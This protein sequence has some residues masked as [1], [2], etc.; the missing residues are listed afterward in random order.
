MDG[1]DLER[2]LSENE[3]PHLDFKRAQYPFIGATDE[4]KCELLKD[5]LAFAN[6]SRTRD[7][8]I[9]IGVEEVKGGRGIL[10]GVS[11]H[12]DDA[13]L[14]QFVN[15]KTQRAIHFS[16]QTVVADGVS[17]DAI[18]V[19][20]QRRPFFLRKDYGKLRANVVYFRRGTTT[21]EANPDEIAA[22]GEESAKL[23]ALQPELIVQFAHARQ[24]LG[25]GPTT[26]TESGPSIDF[27]SLLPLDPALLETRGQPNPWLGGHLESPTKAQ[28]ASFQ[29][30][31]E[32][33]SRIL[34]MISY[35]RFAITN[36]GPSSALN[37]EARIMIPKGRGLFAATPDQV[38]RFRQSTLDEIL[39]LTKAK[40]GDFA[41]ASNAGEWVA[42][43]RTERI[44][45]GHSFF[46]S[47]DVCFGATE[48]GRWK[49]DAMI[50]GDN[51]P[52]PQK[53]QLEVAVKLRT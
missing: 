48:T 8:F 20:I 52:N 44:L 31:V 10:H 12:F 16:V 39:G 49:C 19:P 47:E 3:S 34:N 40:T 41:L 50:Y 29:T 35:A 2:L 26:Y 1:V 37:V 21:V 51:L 15:G 9:L 43:F 42:R 18:R 24:D 33:N 36:R 23:D 11:S 28:G 32:E 17:L 46:A 5:I 25:L 4:V 45:P 27:Q 7:G 22:M 6:G 13:M 38:W 30:Q 53:C 14:Q